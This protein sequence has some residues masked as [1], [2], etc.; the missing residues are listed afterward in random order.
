MRR[1]GVALDAPDGWILVG[2]A[3][4]ELTDPRRNDEMLQ[5]VTAASGGRLMTATDVESLAGLLRARATDEAPT[6]YRDVWHSGWIF[7][8]IVGLLCAEWVIRRQAGLR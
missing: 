3:D 1:A 4:R 8:F 5:R 6:A 2:G 7:T